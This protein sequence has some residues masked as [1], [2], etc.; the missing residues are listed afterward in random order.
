MHATPLHCPYCG[1]GDIFPTAEESVW[2]CRTCQRQ[3]KLEFVRLGK[4]QED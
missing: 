1:E 4:P 3:W 2:F